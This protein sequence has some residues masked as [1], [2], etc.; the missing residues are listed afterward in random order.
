LGLVASLNR[1]GANLS[2]AANLSAELAPKQ[3]QLLRELIPKAPV[4]GILADPAFPGIQS[5]IADLQVGA[6]SLGMQLVIASAR[7][8]TD[9]EPAFATFSQH[10]VAPI[11]MRGNLTDMKYL[12]AVLLKPATYEKGL[13]DTSASP[14]SIRQSSQSSS[15]RCTAEGFRWDVTKVSH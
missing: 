11:M 3:L 12:V 9:L 14:P 15:L 13:T 7:T 8:D 4:F 10:L 6:R 1:P 5:I 2:G